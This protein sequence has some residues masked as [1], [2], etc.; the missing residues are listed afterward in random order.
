MKFYGDVQFQDDSHLTFD[1]SLTVLPSVAAVGDMVYLNGKTYVCIN[2]TGPEWAET[3]NIQSFYLH[4]QAVAADPWSIAHN[5]GVSDIIV[6]VYDASDNKIIPNEVTI[7]DSNNISIDFGTAQAGKAVILAG[8]ANGV[9]SGAPSIVYDIGGSTLQQPTDGEVLSRF[10]AVRDFRMP[11]SLTGS[12]ASSVTATTGVTA[13]PIKKNGTQVG[14]I[15]YAAAATAGT[16]TFATQTDFTSGDIL[17][18]E[19]PATADATH[20]GLVWTFKCTTI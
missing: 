11:V 1:S 2:A 5:L 20:D 17:T 4:T 3:T 15:D 10:I 7:T 13:Y 14:T 19:A 6:N 16:F 18:V 12:Q 9:A 8:D